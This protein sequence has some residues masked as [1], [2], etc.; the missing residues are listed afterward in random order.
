MPC[1]PAAGT[2]AVTA[3]R[4]SLVDVYPVRVREGLLQLLVLRRAPGGR[5]PG[6]FEAVHGHIEG[7]EAPAAA[8]R[9]ELLEETGL[10]AELSDFNFFNT[11]YVR[12]PD[13]DFTYHTF[14]MILNGRPNVLIKEDEHQAYKWVTPDESLSLNLVDDLDECIKLFYKI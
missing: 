9:R 11:V 7:G 1:S 4:V 5:C 10:K 14:S 2:D 8:A 13:Y 3:V 12:Y 6:S